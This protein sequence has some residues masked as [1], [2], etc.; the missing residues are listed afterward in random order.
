MMGN[1]IKKGKK[2]RE[3]EREKGSLFSFEENIIS[4]FISEIQ[5]NFW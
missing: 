2:G 1:G 3:R 5:I 4:S